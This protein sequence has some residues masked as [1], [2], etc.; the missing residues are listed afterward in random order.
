M[1]IR[2]VEGLGYLSTLI[3]DETAGVA[4]VVDPRRDVYVY[5]RRPVTSMSGSP[6]R[7]GWSDFVPRISDFSA[8]VTARDPRRIARSFRERGPE[9]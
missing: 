9:P 2:P 5:P 7:L 6:A 8:I 1:L 3:T 4:A